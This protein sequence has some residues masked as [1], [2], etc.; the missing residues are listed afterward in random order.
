M[1]Y[2]LRHLYRGNSVKEKDREGW[3]LRARCCRRPEALPLGKK[4]NQGWQ[5]PVRRARMPLAMMGTVLRLLSGA[6]VSVISSLFTFEDFQ[7]FLWNDIL[8]V[9]SQKFRHYLCLLWPWGN[10]CMSSSTSFSMDK[11]WIFFFSAGNWTSTSQTLPYSIPDF[12][13][14]RKGVSDTYWRSPR[15]GIKCNN[16][17]T[18]HRVQGKL[19]ATWI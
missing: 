4:I 17:H 19:L 18:I 3:T 1:L 15:E 11:M 10:Y 2:H 6:P 7:D 14:V 12:Q 8:W 16:A 9:E 13:L 5:N